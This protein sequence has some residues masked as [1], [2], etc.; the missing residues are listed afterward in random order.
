VAARRLL[1]LLVALLVISSIAAALAPPPESDESSSTTTTTVPEDDPTA[2]ADGASVVRAAVDVDAAGQRRPIRAGVGDQLSLSV[3]APE[4]VAVEIPRLGLYGTAAPGAPALFDVILRDEGRLEVLAGAKR[5]VTIV[6][7]TETGSPG[8]KEKPGQDAEA[9][10]KD[11][12]TE[13]QPRDSGS[14]VAA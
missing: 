1:A 3:R 13:R 8:A 9:P 10:E 11:R 7:G 4:T 14:S 6:V 12:P 2:G 5:V